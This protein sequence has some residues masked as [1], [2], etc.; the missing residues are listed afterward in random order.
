M[1]MMG[2]WHELTNDVS[3]LAEQCLEI[4]CQHTQ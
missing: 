1:S 3:S 4:N 2:T